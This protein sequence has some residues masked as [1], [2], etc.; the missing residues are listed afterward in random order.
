[1]RTHSPR[2]FP[3]GDD[4]PV[5]TCQGK[6]KRRSKARGRRPRLRTCLCKGCRRKY[7]PR[8]WNQRYCQEPAC[9]RRVR[10]WQAARRQAKHRQN[11]RA[12][13]RHAEAE[14]SRRQQA[15]LASQVDQKP[16]VTPARG[17]ADGAAK[18]FFP[19]PY[20]TGQAATNRLW[21]RS[22]TRHSTVAPPV[23]RRL[24]MSMIANASGAFALPTMAVRSELTNTEPLASDSCCDAIRLPPYRCGPLRSD[25]SARARGS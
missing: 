8:R 18:T 12:K 13:A 25:D 17:H 6:G 22:V 21:L 4:P 20:A 2:A 3:L 24:A 10:R 9:R 15:K 23:V 14:K 16:E 19:L 1:M 11:D 7:L 5:G